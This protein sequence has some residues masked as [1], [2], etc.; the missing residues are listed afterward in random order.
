VAP[1]HWG[2]LLA[3]VLLWGSSYM[4]VELALRALSPV[5]ITGLRISTAALVLLLALFASGRRLPR[6]PRFW[7]LATLMALVGNITPFFLISWGQQEL[8]SALAGILAA[9]TPLC[10]LLLAHFTLPDERLERRQV[11]AFLLA[12]A[13]VAVLLGVEALTGLGGSLPRVLAQLAVI[14]AAACYGMAT[15]LARFMQGPDPLVTAA[16]VML[17][18][19][20]LLSPF[21]WQALPALAGA[22][23]LPLL[24][25][26]VLGVLGTGVAAIIYFYLVGQVG[27][28]FVSLLNYLVPVWAA[29]LGILLLGEVLPVSAWL[30]L[31]MILGGLVLTRKRSQSD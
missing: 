27:A 30:A 4:L 2:L 9:T 7:V 12:F 3:L 31:A 20:L 18:A 23:G 19:A 1:V 15:V 6:D 24:A 13:G 10:V 26:A 8:E 17:M 25:L 14:A 11:A 21:T 22:G 29:G 16:T 28:R 5:E